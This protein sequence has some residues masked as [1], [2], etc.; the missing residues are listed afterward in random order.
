MVKSLYE[1]LNKLSD[2]PKKRF[3]DNFTGRELDDKIWDTAG[4]MAVTPNDEIDGGMHCDGVSGWSD[5]HQNNIC[6]FSNPCSVIWGIRITRSNQTNQWGA[7]MIGEIPYDGS[8]MYATGTYGSG[9][10]AYVQM[11]TRNSTGQANGVMTSMPFK[12]TYNW[13]KYQQ[14]LIHI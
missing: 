1:H 9:A 2:P 6:H 8:G 14:S 4:N 13:H 12:G 3:V 7:G 5:L 11:V 10:S